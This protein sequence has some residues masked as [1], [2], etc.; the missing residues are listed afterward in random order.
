MTSS[1]STHT[2]RRK[3]G[4]STLCALTLLLSCA[5]AETQGTV[6]AK[7]A[8]AREQP[9]IAR[10][11]KQGIMRRVTPARFDPAGLNARG[12]FAVSV[13]KLFDLPAPAHAADYLDVSPDSPFHA[14][15]QAVSP[16]LGRQMRCFGCQLT[17]SL[18]PNE[19]VSRLEAVITLTN[20]LVAQNKVALAGPQ[21]AEPLLRHLRGVDERG[22]PL[23]QY[24]AT[25][26][27]GHVLLPTPANSLA[28]DRPF[29]RADLAAL[30]D[31]VQRTYH[32]PQRS[33]AR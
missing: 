16:Y 13:Q 21:A 18:G 19:P 15:V 25:A 32:V 7:S 31:R 26:I 9:A 8:P 20:I 6:S 33:Y 2:R 10:M 4:R 3:A 22:G 11:V 27:Q 17:L 28:P 29:T 24:V 5:R 23:R 12:D 1:F 30:L 14:A